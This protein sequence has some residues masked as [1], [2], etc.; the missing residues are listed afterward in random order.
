MPLII[1]DNK[2]M[3]YLG[4]LQVIINAYTYNQVIEN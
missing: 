1:T 3:L 4:D 2:A